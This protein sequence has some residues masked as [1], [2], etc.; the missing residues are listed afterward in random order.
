[1]IELYGRAFD[2]NFCIDPAL[3]ED[4]SRLALPQ[5]TFGISSGSFFRDNLTVR[6]YPSKTCSASFRGLRVAE[7]EHGEVRQP[8]QTLQSF[9]GDLRVDKVE[10]FEA[11]QPR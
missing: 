1:M 3:A 10:A 9:V 8:L 6:Q 2:Y 7:L 5:N 11:L 4:N